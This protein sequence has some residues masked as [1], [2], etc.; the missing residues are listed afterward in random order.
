MK[1]NLPSYMLSTILVQHYV[2]FR[3]AL[4]WYVANKPVICKKGSDITSPKPWA[5]SRS[6]ERP[7]KSQIGVCRNNV[8]ARVSTSIILLKVTGVYLIFH[9]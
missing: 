8:E 1:D 9:K 5:S 4:K 7:M 6:V 2:Y 3:I